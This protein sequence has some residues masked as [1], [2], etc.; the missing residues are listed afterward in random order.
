MAWQRRLP[1]VA[2]LAAMLGVTAT[3][4]EDSG[5]TFYAA[6]RA[7]DLPRLNGILTTG[8]NV[9]AKDERGI[10]PLMYTAWVGSVDA[11]RRLLDRGADPNLSNSSGSTALML[12]TTE[13]AKVRLLRGSGSR[14]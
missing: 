2:V 5:E 7:N 6:I 13:I 11:M 1:L 12:S 9:N 8:A 4:Q 10:T 3:S 14:G